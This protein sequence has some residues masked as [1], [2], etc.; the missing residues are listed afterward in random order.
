MRKETKNFRFTI[1]MTGNISF[2][3]ESEHKGDLTLSGVGYFFPQEEINEQVDYDLDEVLFNDINIMPVLEWLNNGSVKEIDDIDDA[4]VAHLHGLFR[5]YD[6]FE[7]LAAALS[8][9]PIKKAS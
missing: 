5:P 3:G 2:H 1:P 8:P 9:S 6:V 4:I 7:S